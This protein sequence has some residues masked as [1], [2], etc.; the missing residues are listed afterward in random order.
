LTSRV[1]LYVATSLDGYIADREGAVD[2]LEAH[3]PRP[4]GFDRFFGEV[5][6]VIMGRRTY[7]FVRAIGDEWPYEGKRTYVLSSRTLVGVPNGVIPTARGL[8]GALGAAR[9]H[10]AKDIW[11]V[12]GAV[13][14]QSALDGG[15]VDLIDLFLVPILL[16]RGLPFVADLQRR[17]LLSFE[18]IET[19]QD[20]IVKLSYTTERAAR[21]DRNVAGAVIRKYV[22]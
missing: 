19:F 12:G 4:Y 15:L 6:A 21:R 5:G 8:A 2:W 17:Q 13:T 1:R 14:M 11:I 18:G 20:G 9:E 3:D 10:T 16:G 7:E 22:P